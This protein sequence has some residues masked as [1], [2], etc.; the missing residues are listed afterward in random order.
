M[1]VFFD[2]ILDAFDGPFEKISGLAQA[3]PGAVSGE[4]NPAGFLLSHQANDAFIAANRLLREGE[5]AFWLK[6]AFEL[7]GKAYPPGTMYIPAGPSTPLTLQ[8][9]ARELGLH[10]E[11][12][13][14]PPSSSGLALRPVRIG[15]W[16][17]YGGSM[18]SGW[19]R[20]LLERYEFPFEVV[21][22]PELDAGRLASRFDVL[23]FPGGAIPSLARAEE[24]EREFRG[25]PQPD[26]ENIPPE[27]RGRLGFVT[28]QKTIPEL[29][30]FLEDGGTILAI[31]SSTSI[32]YHLQ[33]PVANLLVEKL[34]DGTE[35]PLPGE[36]YFIPGSVLQTRVDNSDPLAYGLGERV[37]V[38]FNNSPVFA[39][40]PDAPLSGV[41]PVAWFE[42]KSPLRSGWAWGQHY[43][44]GG[45]AV[46]SAA[47]GKG[48][49]FLFG[50]EITFRAQP[51]GTFKFLFNGIFAAKVE[52]VVLK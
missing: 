35:K 9:M 44:E 22:P 28:A 11:G 36:K 4:M 31:G 39:L 27:Y 16:D 47:V 37:D 40:K 2:R 21:Y 43:L 42:T 7:K 34:P 41:K 23:I 15:L 32:A 8:K 6:E 52:D 13:A 29:R 24:G 46:I 49:L 1:G 38:F 18:P 12:V 20:W 5:S 51:H 10:F 26:P 30:Q 14:A 33:L 3:P 25:F 50:P 17:S 45:V 48:K 19:I